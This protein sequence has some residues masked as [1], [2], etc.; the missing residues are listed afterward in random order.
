[1]SMIAW[2]YVENSFDISKFIS[3]FAIVRFQIFSYF[4][5]N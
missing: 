4:S 5:Q 3:I 2:K 1:M